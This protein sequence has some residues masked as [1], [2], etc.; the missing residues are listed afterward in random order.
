MKHLHY[1]FILSSIGLGF[2][3]VF[4]FGAVWDI[5]AL[6]AT[7]WMPLRIFLSAL[8]L[9]AAGMTLLVFGVT[10][11]RRELDGKK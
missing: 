6:P 10:G 1:R 5:H 7:D 9:A 8:A 3:G 11:I 2:S 4:L